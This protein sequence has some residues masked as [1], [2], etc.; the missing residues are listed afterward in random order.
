MAPVFTTA[1]LPLKSVVSL[2]NL[3]IKCNATNLI[4]N[5]ANKIILFRKILIEKLSRRLLRSSKIVVAYNRLTV[6]ALASA[7]K[8]ADAT[9]DGASLLNCTPAIIAVSREQACSVLS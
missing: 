6:L 4:V 7:R 8:S 9:C 3:L 2:P 1:P 5:E